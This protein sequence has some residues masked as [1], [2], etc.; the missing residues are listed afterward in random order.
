V[1]LDVKADGTSQ[2][3]AWK[4]EKSLAPPQTFAAVVWEIKILKSTFIISYRQEAEQRIL[5][6]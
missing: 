5:F 3:C 2:L 4:D 6:T 1:R